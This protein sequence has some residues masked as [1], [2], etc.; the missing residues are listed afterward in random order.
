M[1]KIL[2]VAKLE[3][4]EKVK[5]KTFIISLIITPIIIILFSVLP[6]ILFSEETPKVEVIGVI[7]TSG[8]YFKDLVDQLDKYKLA[9]GQN[10]YVLINHS[11]KNKN[12]EELKAASNK[13]SGE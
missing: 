4:L 8:V 13:N 12:F 6:S 5:T 11:F 1:K 10:N 9:D 7:D 2:A 3:Y